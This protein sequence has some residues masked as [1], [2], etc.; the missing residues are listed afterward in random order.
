MKGISLQF[1]T[2]IN[3]IRKNVTNEEIMN[4]RES[5]DFCY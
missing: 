5:F 2:L 4:N 1:D 3:H